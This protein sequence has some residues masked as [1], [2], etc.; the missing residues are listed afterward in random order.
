MN[1]GWNSGQVA[2]ASTISAASTHSTG[3]SAYA[4]SARSKGWSSTN[5][6]AS[7]PMLI[8]SAMR[9][10]AADLAPQPICGY[11]KRSSMPAA[12]SC[13][14]ACSGSLRLATELRMPRASRVRSAAT[15]SVRVL[16]L[17]SSRRMPSHRL[18]SRSHTTHLMRPPARVGADDHPEH[19]MPL[20]D[21]VP[22]R[23]ETS[24]VRH[25]IALRCA[26]ELV[27]VKRRYS[28]Q[29]EG[30]VAPD[31][32]GLLHGRERERLV[33]ER[34]GPGCVGVEAERLLH[35]RGE[36]PRGGPCQERG[37]RQVEPRILA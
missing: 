27:V 6:T 36:G 33:V 30:G 4:T 24:E 25:R 2:T 5:A 35:T 10:I 26:V 14:V 29:R 18:S 22:G 31:E 1:R 11:R 7:S 15:T 19:G 20:H 9:V 17:P 32:V 28:T 3:G 13:A 37:Q 12:H 34:P 21:E 23:G 16:T 8:S